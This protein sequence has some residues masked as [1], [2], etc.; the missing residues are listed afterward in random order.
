MDNQNMNDQNMETSGINS[1]ASDSQPLNNGNGQ[2][3]TVFQSEYTPTQNSYQGGSYNNNAYQGSSYQNGSYQN[4]TY[5][6]SSYGGNAYI[7]TPQQSTH[8]VDSVVSELKKQKGIMI[9]ALLTNALLL[10]VFA[11]ITTVMFIR[12]DMVTEEMAADL[13]NCEESICKQGRTVNAIS[14]GMESI[15]EYMNDEYSYNDPYYDPYIDYDYDPYYDQYPAAEKPVIYIYPENE[16]DVEVRLRLNDGDMLC[17]YPDP[18]MDGDTY[19]WNMRALPDGTLYDADGTEYSYLFWE[20]TNYAEP[21]FSQGFC[22][23][24]EDTAEFLRTTLAEIGLTPEEYNE[25]IVYWLPRMQDNEYNLISFQADCYDE[26]CPLEII[27][28]D[29]EEADVLR[30]MMA[31][32][33]VDEYVEIEPQSFEG[34]ERTGFSVVEWG[35]E[36]VK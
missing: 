14:N 22:V 35:G 18:V 1:A 5:Q 7:P 28:A 21:D 30:V 16:T 13:A 2:A 11:G 6:N 34:F 26:A 4:A 33:A 36:E 32:Q 20:A 10:I 19:V 24:G 29:G 17:T 27:A 23:K 8:T 12:M 15:V 9:A 31:W 25:F 3:G